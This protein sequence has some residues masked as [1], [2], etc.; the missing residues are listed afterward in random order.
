[1][2]G[3]SAAAAEYNVLA[4]ICKARGAI[5]RALA[6]MEAALALCIAR[7]DRHRC[8]D[9]DGLDVRGDHLDRGGAGAR[10]VG[11]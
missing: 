4:L 8:G 10:V 5:D 3:N 6:L 9:A 2:A 1:M 11:E 7:G